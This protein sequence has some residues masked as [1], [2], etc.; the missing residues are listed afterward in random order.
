ME[1]EMEERKMSHEVFGQL[2]DELDGDGNEVLKVK[3]ARYSA[4]DDALHN[5]RAGANFTGLTPAQTCW[6]YMS[7]HLIALKDMIDR[8]DFSNREDFLE[9]CKDPINYLRI[10]WAIGNDE[11]YWKSNDKPKIGSPETMWQEVTVI[12]KDTGKRIRYFDLECEAV[13]EKLRDGCL[14]AYI[15]ENRNEMYEIYQYDKFECKINEGKDK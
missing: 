15:D 9:K 2:L 1:V 3:N 7:K 8:N 13:V 11:E 5:F 10:L 6:G 4:P 12:D 14:I